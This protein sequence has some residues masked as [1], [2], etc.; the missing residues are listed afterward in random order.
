MLTLTMRDRRR[1]TAAVGALMVALPPSGA[2]T[3]APSFADSTT[4]A[5]DL[6]ASV[7]FSLQSQEIGYGHELVASGTTPV[8]Q[9]APGSATDQPLL[10]QFSRGG[11]SSW[12][13]L[14]S[15]TTLAGTRFKLSARMT[16]SG[17]VRVID[18]TPGGSPTVQA[19][20]APSTTQRV[21]VRG[22]LSVRRQAIDVL[23]G[24]AVVLR[25]RLR[26]GVSRRVILLQGRTGRSWHTLASARTTGLG[27]F[28]I[29][30]VAGTLGQQEL[31]VRF[32]GD[33]LNAGAWAGAGRLTVYQQ[34]VASWYYDGG[35]TAC[36]FSALYGVANRSLPCGSRIEFRLGSREVTAVVDDRGPYVGGRD[37]DLNQ[38]TAAALGLVGVQTLW[39]TK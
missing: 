24:S 18:A 17:E 2:L 28:T 25:G 27:A 5:F 21:V 26:P 20:V 10:L 6:Q 34:S 29:R 12:Q 30:Y 16:M 37:W 19:G 11:S 23:G 9:T 3:P 35:A 13:T 7:P 15:A 36:G 39:S 4:Q 38:N 14:A 32:S 22:L 8:T 1:A 31:R 33:R